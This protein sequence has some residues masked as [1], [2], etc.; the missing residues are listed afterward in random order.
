MPS[1]ETALCDSGPL[2]ALF[3][4][5]DAAH[6]Q[7]RAFLEAF[8]GQL[9]TTWPILSEVFHFAEEARSRQRLWRFITGG[10]LSIY[11]M[12]PSEVPRLQHFMARYADL[13]MHLADA[14]LVVAAERLK[15]RKIFTLDRR[16]FSVYRP[17]HVRY[18]EISP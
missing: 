16:D 11:E 12:S 6:S 4:P 10:G 18:F 5:D 8:N 7:C 3:D 14:S 9:V 15:L 1:V 13:P 2:I 17:Q